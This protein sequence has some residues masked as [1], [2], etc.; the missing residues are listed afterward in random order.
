MLAGEEDLERPRR[1]L[2]HDS[3]EYRLR[4]GRFI[5]QKLAGVGLDRKALATLRIGVERQTA[6]VAP[7]QTRV[8]GFGPVPRPYGDLEQSRTTPV[9]SPVWITIQ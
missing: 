2:Q 3:V 9:L 5:G 7:G 8:P 4:A 1:S 6:G